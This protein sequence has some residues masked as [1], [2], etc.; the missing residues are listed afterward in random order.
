MAIE[1]NTRDDVNGFLAR[2]ARLLK[3]IDYAGTAEK[4]S[5]ARF[6]RI[7]KRKKLLTLIALTDRENQNFVSAVEPSMSGNVG[8]H[9]WYSLN[10]V[11]LKS[12]RT[13][14]LI[15]CSSMSQK[16]KETILLAAERG[17]LIDDDALILNAD[18]SRDTCIRILQ[19]GSL[20]QRISMTM[21]GLSEKALTQLLYTAEE[22][23]LERAMI[24]AEEVA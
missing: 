8:T 20:K 6:K 12:E 17:R 13:N 11:L 3:E 10:Y 1:E 19:F 9:A 7:S 2:G 4:D 23:L 22:N 15:A 14:E 18:E 21:N 16:L 5:I 24:W